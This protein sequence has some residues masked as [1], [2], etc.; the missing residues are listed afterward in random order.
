VSPSVGQFVCD[1]DDKVVLSF[2]LEM[3]RRYKM[4]SAAFGE[5]TLISVVSWFL[6]I[7]LGGGFGYGCALVARRILKASASSGRCAILLPWRTIVISLLLFL[8]LIP[9]AVGLGAFAGIAMA[10]L[11]VFVLAL[12]FT[13]TMLH[14]TWFPTS[15]ASRLV[16]GARS[17]AVAS[18]IIAVGASFMGGGAI[19]IFIWQGKSRPD[20]LALSMVVLLALVFD[21]VLGLVQMALTQSGPILPQAGST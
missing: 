18:P 3:I 1:R 6:G 5:F 4:N 19:G 15:L 16:I 10:G 9:V 14:E 13:T 2:L 20:Y 21:E 7:V 8:P 12:M 17:I 11:G